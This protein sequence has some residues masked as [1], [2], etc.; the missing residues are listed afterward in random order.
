MD[1]KKAVPQIRK[2]EV[3]KVKDSLALDLEQINFFLK[4]TPPRYTRKRPAKGGGQWT[5]VSGGYVK[6]VLNLAFGWDW[7]FEIV[8]EI[9]NLEARQVIVKGRLTVRSNGKS[10]VK[11]QYGRQD[12]KFRNG[13]DTPLDLGNDLKGAATDALKKCAADLGIAADIYNPEEYKEME[14]VEGEVLSQDEV[15][16]EEEAKR[17][18]QWIAANPWDIVKASITPQELSNPI[19]NEAFTKKRGA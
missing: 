12:L 15:N 13:T 19:I 2:E 11:M 5:Y 6:K 14:I 1:S 8:D 9:V 16:R 7:D 3:I 18:A 10:I 4:R 17:T